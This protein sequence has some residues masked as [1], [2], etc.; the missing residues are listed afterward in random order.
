MS[1]LLRLCAV[2]LMAAAPAAAIAQDRMT[3]SEQAAVQLALDRGQLLYAYDQAAWHGT[4]DV[5]ARTRDAP[6][7]RDTVGG[8]IVDGTANDP[9]LVFFD[10]T[11]T[12]AIYT[13]RFADGGERLVEGRLTGADGDAVL[14][15]SRQ[16]MIRAQRSAITAVTKA[17]LSPCA[18]K[19][20]NTVVLP[21]TVPG[22]ASLVYFL[23][24]QT[25]I[26]AFPGGGHYR[27]EVTADDRA[28]TP[29][30]FAKSCIM[31]SKP[32][33]KKLPEALGVTHLL[34]PTPT[35]VHVFTM[36]AAKIPLYVMTS[37]ARRIWVVES[38]GGQAR[39]R[40]VQAKS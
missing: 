36:L 40:L 24:P 25:E 32:T 1:F 16:Q 21:P 30:A 39:I 22:A 2:I 29:R 14:S 35:E 26:N 20:F 18:A 6:G 27:V 34:D 31:L 23:T 19:P 3:P 12:H 13:A 37:G 7:V 28:S 5:M 11:G 4:D 17:K 8:W 15:A 10:K 33:G 9:R 38:I